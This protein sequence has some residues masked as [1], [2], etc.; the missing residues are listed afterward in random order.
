[1]TL[2]TSSCARVATPGLRPV[3]RAPCSPSSDRSAHIACSCQQMGL[4]GQHVPAARAF[5][6]GLA[7]PVQA[8]AAPCHA[9][10]MTDDLAQWITGLAARLETAG[11]LVIPRVLIGP[12]ANGT[13][14]YTGP[15]DTDAYLTDLAR[16]GARTVHAGVTRW[17]ADDSQDLHDQIRTARRRAGTP[18]PA[19][20]DTDIL[21]TA[22]AHEGAPCYALAAAVVDGIRYLLAAT[23]EWVTALDQAVDAALRTAD[24]RNRAADAAADAAWAAELAALEAIRARLDRALDGLVDALQ[25]DEEFLT[26]AGR[27]DT[28]RRAYA[29]ALLRE[30]SGVDDL[31]ADVRGQASAAAETAWRW[32]KTTGR[33]ARTA[34]LRDKIP[35][36]TG[37]PDLTGT[38]AQR[39][40]TAKRLLTDLD[41]AAVTPDLVEELARSR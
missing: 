16:L 6:S 20:G 19:P 3:P 30:R 2:G 36:L 22:A 31:P 21:A 28:T 11:H 18:F 9:D 7:A 26:S 41:P 35:G 37:H 38:L 10:P 29:H 23:A 27:A 32:W 12:A 39:R 33:P 14:T 17:T 25:T 5:V 4:V 34:A 13:V 15:D 24:T 40:A 1:M 8:V